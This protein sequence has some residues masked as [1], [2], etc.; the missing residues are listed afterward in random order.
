MKPYRLQNNFS[1]NVAA[2]PN[3]NGIIEVPVIKKPPPIDLNRNSVEVHD[4]LHDPQQ[5]GDFEKNWVT[6]EELENRVTQEHF[7]AEGDEDA[8]DF[9]EDDV[10]QPPDVS[11]K[12]LENSPVVGIRDDEVIPTTGE[13]FSAW[14]RCARCTR[15]PRSSRAT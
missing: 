11:R 6:Q 9:P 12:Q 13:F 5:G 7:V 3:F 1:T 2:L 15:R 4:P 8:A 14:R 10:P